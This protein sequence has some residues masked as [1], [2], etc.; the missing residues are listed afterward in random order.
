LQN[1]QGGK[2]SNSFGERGELKNPN[3]ENVELNLQVRKNRGIK[4]EIKD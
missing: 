1:F 3:L 4:S 2:I